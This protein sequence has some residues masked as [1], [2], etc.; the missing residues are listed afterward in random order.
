MWVFVGLYIGEQTLNELRKRV[1][2]WGEK[3]MIRY[4]WRE[5]KNPY[6]ILI[7]EVLL[8]RT[9]AEQVNPVYMKFIRRYENIVAL[10]DANRSEV[11]R[12]L[13][14]LGLV[15]RVKLMHKMAKEIVTRF[16]ARVPKEYEALTSL[17]G[18]GDYI[19]SA[20]RCFAFGYPEPIL[21][22]NTV[23][24]IG[25]C[26]GL[27]ITDSSRRSK[28]YRSLLGNLVDPDN[29]AMFNYSLLDLGKLVCKKRQQECSVCPLIQFCTFTQNL[30]VTR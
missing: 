10:A 27:E 12:L 3:H 30:E 4:P 28:K 16:E 17:P 13:S 20:V 2:D 11:E 24:I 26:F 7:V 9:R 19:A 1:L 23:R 5:T 29:P 21:D 22:T 18:I 25:R 14:S 6:H 15:W 8:H